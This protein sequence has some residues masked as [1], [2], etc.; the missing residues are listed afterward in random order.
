MKGRERK[1]RERNIYMNTY[2]QGQKNINTDLEK[3]GGLQRQPRKERGRQRNTEKDTQM[4]TE[5][6]QNEALICV[7]H[8]Y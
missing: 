5:K 3:L 7:F 8:I 4:K 6:I 2:I 1:R